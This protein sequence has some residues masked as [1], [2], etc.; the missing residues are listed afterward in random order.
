MPKA[1]NTFIK[2]KL[3]KDLDARLIPNGEYR[4]AVNV[5]VSRSESAS[6]GSLENVLGNKL[7]KNFADGGRIIGHKED[8][9]NGFIYLFSS[10]NRIYRYDIDNDTSLTLVQGSFLNFSQE[11]PIFGINILEDFLYWTDN[12]NQPRKINITTAVAQGSSYYDTEDKISVAKYYPYRSIEMF[13]ETASAG[14]LETTMKDVVSLTNPNGGTALAAGGQTGTTI[15]IDNINGDIILPNQSYS[16][17]IGAS[18]S[19]RS[20]NAAGNF[21]LTA[22]NQTVVSVGGGTTITS[23]TLTGTITVADNQM[24]VFNPN[25]KF[26]G[27]FNGD[28]DYL[29][30]LFVR[31]SYRF[32]FKDGEYSLMA[33]FTQIAFIPKQDGYFMYV[34]KGIN[35]IDDKDDLAQT[36]RSTVVSFVENKVNEIKLIIPKP[37]STTTTASISDEFEISE[38]DILFKESDGLVVKVVE[39]IPIDSSNGTSD[40]IYNYK[41]T[42]PFKTLPSDELTRVYDKVPVRAFA[43]EVI[44]NRI[45][46]GN[47]Q[48]KHTPPESLD[49]SIKVDDK[50]LASLQTGTVT[51]QGGAQSGTTIN[52]TN[53]AGNIK[54]AS[55]VSGTGIPAGTVVTSL[56]NTVPNITQIVISQSAT[57]TLG[58]LTFTPAAKDG[59]FTSR[60]EY[61]N[62]S[63]KQNR[64]YQVGVVLADRY[65]RQSSVILN[66]SNEG[67]T[68]YNA[69]FTSST[70]TVEWPGD[71]LKIEFNSVIGPAS[72]VRGT[73]AAGTAEGSIEWPGIY[74][75]NNPLGWYS[76][77]IVVKQTEQDYYNVYLPG[78]MASYPGSNGETLEVGSTSHAVLINDNINKVPRDLNEVGPEQKQFRSSVRLLPRVIN[79]DDSINT[80]TPSTNYGLQSEQF[81]AG[82]E[83]ETVSMISTMRD[84]FEVPTSLSST[85]FL[86]FY[87]NESNP[88]ISRIS[89]STKLG[90]LKTVN[91]DTG[92]QFLAVCETEPVD[93]LLDIFWE[94]STSGT[95]NGLNTLIQN[96]IGGITNMS[97]FAPTLFKESLNYNPASSAEIL[98]SDF[99]LIDSNGAAQVPTSFT[100]SSVVNQA[101]VNVSSYFDLVEIGGAGTGVYNIIIKQAYWNN[102]FFGSNALLRNFVFNFT[103]VYQGVTTTFTETANLQNVAPTATSV[104]AAGTIYTNNTETTFA[105]LSGINGANNVALR[106]QDLSYVINSQ[107]IGTLNV[108]FFGLGGQ[109]VVSNQLNI[110]LTNKNVNTLPV[111]DYD[112][113]VDLND[114]QGSPATTTYSIKIGTTAV[115]VYNAE[116]TV[117]ASTKR[118]GVYIVVNDARSGYPSSNNGHY[119]LNGIDFNTWLNTYVGSQSSP[120][121]I[122]RKNAV[123]GTP[124]GTCVSETW[125]YANTESAINTIW[126]GD[127]TPN[128][129]FFSKTAVNIPSGVFFQIIEL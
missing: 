73:G 110:N 102:V 107:K 77:K 76:Y 82:Q 45:V 91:P 46:Y 15:N 65:G 96:S 111:G 128:V 34:D 99:T 123:T 80:A 54:V 90:Q 5:Q 62:S 57:N 9:T 97:G 12:R 37:D 101:G 85:G 114:P 21:I 32:K 2:S 14:A 3:N 50:E 35:N 79:T 81:Y 10:A 72:P 7:V 68:I 36:Y 24:L 25:P 26:D 52:V 83:T 69:Y 125:Y 75:V 16:T 48:N 78:I 43:Q 129:G 118:K 23:V 104:P 19:L 17:S 64:N 38:V 53:S 105:T 87:D 122:D 89:T 41:S 51:V 13:Q 6:V 100:I 117:N 58:T 29:Q 8:E 33:P 98:A 115:T 18:V 44:S 67:S 112:V 70:N 1:I 92:I 126:N 119:L 60:A 20:T 127:C 61:P 66:G 31:F 4:D 42:K 121:T 63:L 116:Q 49:Y 84:M 40:I 120:L 86:Q 113:E 56:N 59:N 28:S 108:N 103:A 55:S 30:D 74:S 95:I 22:T 124:P 88:L 39:T 47:F 94:T 93:S 11:N 109:A 27:A 71:S 106:T